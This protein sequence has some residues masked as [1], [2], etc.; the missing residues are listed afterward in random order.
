MTLQIYFAVRKK[1]NQKTSSCTITTRS[2]KFT[3]AQIT[4]F[5]MMTKIRA[6]RAPHQSK[7]CLFLLLLLLFI[8]L[9]IYFLPLAD[10][11]CLWCTE[12]F[13]GRA[14]SFL[15]DGFI[16][17]AMNTV[18]GRSAPIATLAPLRIDRLMHYHSWMY[19]VYNG[20]DHVRLLSLKLDTGSTLYGHLYQPYLR[21]L[22]L[23]LV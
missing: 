18:W 22:Q 4:P 3:T 15:K 7:Q 21:T 8:F 2:L 17:R 6:S 11:K 20:M 19:K 14:Q 9:M 13:T 23:Y 12:C 5:F 10:C 1:E 16:V